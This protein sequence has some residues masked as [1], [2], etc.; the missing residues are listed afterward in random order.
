MR[1]G[2]RRNAWRAAVCV[3]DV[4][5][6][7]AWYDAP[8]VLCARDMMLRE[9]DDDVLAR[10]TDMISARIAYGV[11]PARRCCSVAHMWWWLM[12]L[13]DTD[14]FEP[15]IAVDVYSVMP[16]AYNALARA[17]ILCHCDILIF[18][19][20]AHPA[21]ACAR[22]RSVILMVNVMMLILVVQ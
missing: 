2:M 9:I 18:I 3:Y 6:Q 10:M 19:A 4:V 17:G 12:I 5:R 20:R 1:V 14:V 8:R 22:V 15:V 7:Y 11:W 13:V 16:R 21:R